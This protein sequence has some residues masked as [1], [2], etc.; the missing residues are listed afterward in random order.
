MDYYDEIAKVAYDIFEREGRIHGRHFDHWIEAEMIVT[1]KYTETKNDTEVSKPKKKTAAKTA[2][3][4][5]VKPKTKKT[6]K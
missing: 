3:K 6:S 1:T 5:A 4:T 2:A